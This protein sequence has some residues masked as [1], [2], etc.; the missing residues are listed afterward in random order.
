MLKREMI[1][2]LGIFSLL[3]MIVI[4][5]YELHLYGIFDVSFNTTFALFLGVI[6]YIVG[7]A[8]FKIFPLRMKN[9]KRRIF[10]Y[11]R[12]SI[13][14]A[15][16]FISSF[17]FYIPNILYVIN[18]NAIEV[19][20]TRLVLGDIDAGGA[21]MQYFVRPVSYIV[22]AITAYFVITNRKK[23]LLIILGILFA[24]FD[25][26]GTASKTGISLLLLFVIV[27]YFLYADYVSF[28]K[29]NKRILILAVVGL[30]CFVGFLLG[31][32]GIYFYICGC[33]PMLD[34]IVNEG[35][36]MSSGHSYGFLSF[37]SVIRFFIKILDVFGI[38]IDSKMFDLAN[39][40]FQRF[41]YTT[42]VSNNGNFNAFH[43]MFGDFYVDFGLFGVFVLSLL[44]GILSCWAYKIVKKEKSLWGHVLFCT[45]IF[46]TVF[47]IVRFQ[48]SNTYFGLMLIYTLLFLKPI[49]H[50]KIGV[51]LSR[52]KLS[53][54]NIRTDGIKKGEFKD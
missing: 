34:K 25:F 23:N 38:K 15:L 32:Q 24:I 49:M 10:H 54:S 36:Y 1:S 47:G 30:V 6:G 9:N 20:K 43:T 8:F 18:G 17:A 44:F 35:F 45:I 16:A 41:E 50:G 7:Y 14:A 48:M 12:V 31:F 42:S 11:N 26:A 53:L 27:S 29:R 22:L 52:R 5:L 40:Y 46:Y 21:L 2:P 28:I 39:D 33:V 4:F 19:L 37:N 3:W 13:V 51:K